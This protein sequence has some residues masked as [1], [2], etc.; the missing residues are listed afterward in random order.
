MRCRWKQAL[1]QAAA[2][3]RETPFELPDLL[4]LATI[5]DLEVFLAKAGDWLTFRVADHNRHK[6]QIAGDSQPESRRGLHPA[7]GAFEGLLRAIGRNEQHEHRKGDRRETELPT[8]W[9]SCARH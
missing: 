4:F 6:D 2:L 1:H 3:G 5:E 8:N 9:V 7:V